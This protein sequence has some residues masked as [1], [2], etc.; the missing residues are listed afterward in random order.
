MAGSQARTRAPTA[1]A[2]GTHLSVSRVT[3]SDVLD[4]LSAET[5]VSSSFG[6]Q[7]E[8][9][10]DG[11]TG[12]ADYVRSRS[13][14]EARI[15]ARA[16]II[17]CV[18]ALSVCPNLFRTGE[19]CGDI[20]RFAVRAKLPEGA[21]VIAVLRAYQPWATSSQERGLAEV[22]QFARSRNP[23]LQAADPAGE[24]SIAQAFRVGKAR[25]ARLIA[26]LLLADAEV[27]LHAWV[28][29]WNRRETHRATLS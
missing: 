8:R 18:D 10:R 19:A 15:L 16:A 14:A 25:R 17:R 26:A 9:A 21:A 22:Y 2:S 24:S 28:E 3:L 6:A 29:N 27:A 11:T 13:G 20:R 12:A 1:P 4:H 23:S 7:L 5:T